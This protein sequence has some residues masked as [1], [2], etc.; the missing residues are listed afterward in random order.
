MFLVNCMVLI[1]TELLEDWRKQPNE[2]NVAAAV[3]IDIWNTFYCKPPLREKCPNT[4]LFLVRILPHSDWILR[5]SPYS[6]QMRE[7]TDQK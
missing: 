3:H 7:N 4:E 5:I 1:F 6:V 2:N